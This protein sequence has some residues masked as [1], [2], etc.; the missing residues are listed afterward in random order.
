MD[1]DLSAERWLTAKALH[2]VQI[3]S[4]D[5]C[6]FTRWNCADHCAPFWRLYWHDREG[7][8]LVISGRVVPVKPGHLVLIPPNTHYASRLQN[9][10]QQFFLH[11]L[12][13]PRLRVH[14]ET[15]FQFRESVPMR[16]CRGGIA[17]LLNAGAMNLRASLLAQILVSQALME[18]PEGLWG[19]RFEDPRIT[20]AVEA[21]TRN[22]PERIPNEKLAHEARLHPSAFIRLFRQHTGHTP[23]EYLMNQRLEEACSMLHFDE[24]SIDEIAERTGFSDRAYFTRIFSRA[25][26]CS[27]GRYRKLVNVSERLRPDG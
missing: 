1:A 6:D 7:G 13:E 20:C 17:E 19:P 10:V 24:A 26:N 14:S 18:L 23:V 12:L 5:L 8:E 22:Y 3:L 2:Q 25:M 11:F 27:P 9:P 4:C 21:I 16:E 15:V